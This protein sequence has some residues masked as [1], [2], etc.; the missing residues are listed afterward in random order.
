MTSR[1]GVL[2]PATMLVLAAGTVS[3]A[4]AEP[5]QSTAVGADS[6]TRA[7]AATP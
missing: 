2:V 3:C 5:P 6:T 4:T 1:R 7:L